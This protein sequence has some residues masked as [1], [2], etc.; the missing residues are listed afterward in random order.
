MMALLVNVFL[1]AVVAALALTAAVR[2][3]D[4]FTTGLRSGVRDFVYLLPRVAVGVIGSGYIAAVLPQ[5]L[6]AGSLGPQSGLLGTAI[7]TV[8]GA[9]T[10]GGPV[11]GFSIALAAIKG[12]AGMPQVIAYL[13][14]W[15]LYAFHRLV[16][17]EIA[18]MP[19]RVVWLRAL[20]SLPIPFAAAA[21][22]MLLGRP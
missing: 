20:V 9:L 22:A 11:I 4:L 5:S 1:W 6:I 21:M 10:P 12:G 7:A 19:P 18:V 3:R 17:Y 14:A 13:T 15:A 2:S 8:G 16:M